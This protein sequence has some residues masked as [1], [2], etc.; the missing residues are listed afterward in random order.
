MPAKTAITTVKRGPGRQSTFTQDMADLICDELAKGVP[1]AE[2]CRRQGSPCVRT[3]YDWEEAHP[4]FAAA[5]ARARKAGFDCIATD[6]IT[7]ADMPPAYKTTEGGQSI[8]QGDVANR[9]LQIET[10]L[11]LLAK[12]DPRRYGD[13]IA[14]EHSGKVG[15]E[16]LVAGEPAA[17]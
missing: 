16:S 3:V 11:K 12:W 17:E 2:L 1:L 15:L 7:L 14:H 10:R 9:K 8:D 4:E 5:I 6:T 13:R